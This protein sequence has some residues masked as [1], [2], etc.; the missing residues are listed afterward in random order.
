MKGAPVKLT[1]TREDD[2]QHGYY[3]T[4]SIEH[5]EA[6]LDR[7]GK[8][9][10][11][12]QR[13]AGP[14]I[15]SVF[16]PD[17]KHEQP[18]ELGMGL[19]N[20]PF[21]IPN[22]RIE[23]PEAEAHTRIG[24]YR[25]VS[26]IPHAFAI[27]SFVAEL[28]AAAGRDPKDYLLELVGPARP[29]YPRRPGA[30]HRPA[31]AGRQLELHRIARALCV[32]HRKAAARH[33]NGRA[34]IW[35]GP[36]ASRGA[37]T[38]HRSPLQL[39]HLRRRGSAGRGERKRRGDHSQGRRRCRLRTA[40]QPGAHRRP[41]RRR[42]RDGRRQCAAL[43]DQL[44]GR[45]G[46]AVEFPRLPGRAHERRA[47]RHPRAPRRVGFQ[48]APGRRRRAG[49][50]ADR[51]GPV[52]CDLRRHRQ[53]HPHP[54]DR[55]SAI[56]L[57]AATGMPASFFG[58][59]LGLAGLGGAWRVAARV[60]Q[61]PPVIGEALM[62]TAAIVWAL[63]LGLYAAK[64]I[65][66]REEAL[67]EL[68]HPIQCCFVGLIGVATMLISIAA[69]PYSRLA[70]QIAF[71]VAASFTLAF[72]VWRTRLLCRGGRDPGATTPVL[73]LP[74][75][76]GA[77][78]TA[79]AAAALSPR[80]W[81]QLAFAAGLFSWIALES[82]LLHRLYT[83]ASMPAPR[84]PPLGIQLAPPTVGGVAYLSVTTGTPDMPAHAMLGYGLL[85]ALLLLR[86]LPWIRQQPFAP[87]HL[88]L[89]FGATTLATIPLD[90]M[91]RR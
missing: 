62:L 63:M 27:Q 87:S 61:L 35:L 52:Q 41:V 6:G 81:G 42:L 45:P 67:Q 75:V 17:P 50:A 37:G 25:S 31:H 2:V 47:A 14:A 88:A 1:W 39:R 86:L 83:V 21:L 90:M 79:T 44:Q 29:T 30:P 15:E 8:P 66:A 16:G 36:K 51:A 59:V 9:L 77:F 78:V 40:G 69:L 33:R 80:D 7:P 20:V 10:A 91:E 5:L 54:A 24:W 73:Y 57:R 84:R 65:Y 55:R 89:T 76:A 3:H 38:R 72:A 48:R 60:W 4:V 53:A 22:L 46:R 70:A 43:R 32:R 85:Q 64:W 82:V 71:A 56:R 28:A 23:N 19:V 12:L 49:R 26:N 74:P 18:P 11:C 68:E 13:R 34:R 58:I